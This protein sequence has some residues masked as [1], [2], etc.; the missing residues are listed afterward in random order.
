MHIPDGFLTTG[1][2]VGTGAAS[3]VAVTWMARRA[4][5]ETEEGRVPLLGVMGAFVFAA[6]MINFPVGVGTTGHLLG[7]ALLAFTLGP[8]SAVVVMTAILAVQALVFQDGGVLALGANVLNMAVAGVL[9]GYLPY[10]LLSRGRGRKTAIF[11]GGVLSV[12]TSASLALVELRLSGVPMPRAILGVSLG[13]F[14]VAAMLEGVITLGVIQALEALN[15]GWIVK[16]PA[17]RRP[18]L[19]ALALTA[20][21]LAVLGVSLASTSPDGLN[22]L[23]QQLGIASRARVLISTPLAGYEAQVMT[24]PWLRKAA[25][26]AAGLALAYLAILWLGRVVSRREGN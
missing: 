24:S 25:A 3:A 23:A 22:R 11:L 12:M 5:G 17:L 13:L 9:A 7:G 18:A 16:P 15:P 6:Q 21:L 14:A 1:V 2:Y 19:T 20:V 26:G 4:Q 8:A 10:R